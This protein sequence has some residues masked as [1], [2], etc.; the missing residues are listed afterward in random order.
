MQRDELVIKGENVRIHPTAIV[1]LVKEGQQK[2]E[3]KLGNNVVVG[4]YSVI[5]AGAT[6]GDDC[7]IQERVTLNVPFPNR[8]PLTI[9]SKAAIRSG[10][11]IYSGVKIGNNFETGHNT[12][13]RNDNTIGDDVMVNINAVLCPGNKIGN[14]TRIHVGSFM[15]G[16][17]LGDD[18]F[19]AP[20]VMFSDDP[21]PICPKYPECKGGATVGNKV[22]IG[23]NATIMPGI[24]I[25]DH[26]LV[27]GGSIVTKDLKF[28]FFTYAGTPARPIKRVDELTCTAEFYSFPYEWRTTKEEID[29]ALDPF[30][31]EIAR[32][33][34]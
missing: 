7:E 3:T 21:H 13:I 31:D 30:K 33:K 9:G 32:L 16:T 26:V 11:T 14:R 4:A 1:G 6:I 17:T 8:E 19:I 2:Q 34:Q 22:S 18:V 12:T 20:H 29:A 5:F 10:T 25:A 15:E 24:K 23:A 28:P 27:G